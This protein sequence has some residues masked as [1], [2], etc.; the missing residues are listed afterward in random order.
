MGSAEL[1]YTLR[2]VA[3]SGRSISEKAIAPVAGIDPASEDIVDQLGRML[4]ALNRVEDAAGRPLLSAVV[5]STTGLP[6]P[7]FFISARELGL[8]A[9]NDDHAVWMRE[10]R[11]VQD[12]WARH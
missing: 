3:R 5:V 10:L 12:Y 1:A 11:R 2:A 7:G 4:A 8:L 9:G 6:L